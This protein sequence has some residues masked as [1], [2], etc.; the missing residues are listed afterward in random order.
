[1]KLRD[2][3]RQF[4]QTVDP[5]ER[6]LYAREM[7]AWG[8]FRHLPVI[9]G[10]RVVGLLS[11]R[12]IA[13]HQART[14]ESLASSPGDTVIMAM[15]PEPQTAHPDDSVTEAMAR[16]AGDRIGCLPVVDK[17]SLVGI[18]TTTDLLA[19][20]VRSAMRPSPKGPPV[21]EVMTA[22]PATAHA[23]D[24]LLDA[25]AVMQQRRIRHLPVVDGEGRVLGM[26]SDRDV[27]TLIGD[28]ATAF[29]P[30]AREGRGRELRV[31]DAMSRPAITVQSTD[32]CATASKAFLTHSV[33]ALPVLGEHGR[34]IGIVSYLD[35]LRVLAR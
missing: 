14:G 19:A 7:M 27:R 30:V 13:A 28:P 25:A 8:Q 32:S 5:D 4:P 6:L 2:V 23:D 3:M 10:G 20:E 16:L 33:S 12:D 1:M 18:V 26:L 31:Q 35:L 9:D 22:E 29:D 24:P 21:A 15:T 34:L 11:E 17:G